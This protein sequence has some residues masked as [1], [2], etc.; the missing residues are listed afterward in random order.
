MV[1]T[2]MRAVDPHASRWA[3][4]DFESLSW[5]DCTIHSMGLDQDGEYQSDLVIDLDFLMEWL[6]T[7]EGTYKFQ[8]APALLRFH[9]VD[10]LV[11]RTLLDYKQAMQISEVTRL[12]REDQGYTNYHWTIKLHTYPG[13][14]SQ[15]EFDATGFSQEL[16]AQPLVSNRQSLPL[17]ERQ[18]MIR[19]NGE[20]AAS[21]N[22][23]PATQLGNS[24]VMEGPPSVS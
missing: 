21:P 11:I 6:P 18:R 12:R 9:N 17:G 23:G 15:I 1:A 10:K 19:G 22:G 16:I 2:M 24:G 13:R 8:M 3:D 14:Q 7:P 4:A 5:H 20:P